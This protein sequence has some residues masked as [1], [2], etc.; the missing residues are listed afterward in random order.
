VSRDLSRRLA[1]A[2]LVA[3]AVLLLWPPGA[4][5]LVGAGPLAVLILAGTLALPRWA[6]ATAILMLPYFSYG[7]MEAL[8]NPAGRLQAGIF[9]AL[10][11]FVFLA[12]MDS[13]RRKRPGSGE[14][15]PRED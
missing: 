4:A 9:A 11:I 13:L 12:A 10:T 5:A 3:L 6:I 8:T 15:Q 14:R 7:V 1:L 2:G